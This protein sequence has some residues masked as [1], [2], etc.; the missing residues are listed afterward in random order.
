MSVWFDCDSC[1]DGFLDD[2]P[3]R[4]DLSELVPASASD[5][6]EAIVDPAR[7]AAWSPGVRDARWL[8]PSPPSVGSERRLIHP[9]LRA[10]QR[11]AVLEP[12]RRC[13]FYAV[14][15]GS[16]ALSQLMEEFVL[17]EEPWGTRVR[18]RIG[19][20]LRLPLRMLEPSTVAAASRVLPSHL[21]ALRAYCD[22]RSA[23]RAAR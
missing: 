7:R 5:V 19:W 23:A 17:D 3:A 12:A 6:F 1:W 2:A 10:D 13:A 14:R 4:I 22:A 9:L 16:L 18:W 15:T 11:L 20:R 8:S 21:A